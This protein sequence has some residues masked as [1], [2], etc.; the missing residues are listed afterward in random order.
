MAADAGA[1]PGLPQRVLP[2]GGVELGAASAGVHM[3]AITML[4]M[5]VAACS[6]ILLPIVITFYVTYHFLQLFDGIFSVSLAIAA[7]ALGCQA[8]PHPQHLHLQ[9][10]LLS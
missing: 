1:P 8:H 7:I 9:L 2:T 3:Y 6:A 5:I 10:D 4:M